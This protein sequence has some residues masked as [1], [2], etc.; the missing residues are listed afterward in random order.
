VSALL[1]DIQ[2]PAIQ[3]LVAGAGDRRFDGEGVGAV[4]AE[5]HRV[6]IGGVVALPLD[7]VIDRKT[8][9]VLRGLQ[10]VVD[11]HNRRGVA[12]IGNARRQQRDAHGGIL[13]DAIHDLRGLLVAAGNEIR[14]RLHLDVRRGAGAGDGDRGRKDI[15]TGRPHDGRIWNPDSRRHGN[16]VAVR[17][18]SIP[19][20]PMRAG[21]IIDVLE[22][23]ERCAALRRNLQRCKC[24]L[25]VSRADLVTLVAI[26]VVR[27]STTARRHRRTRRCRYIEYEVIGTV[28][29]VDDRA[30][31]EPLSHLADHAFGF[32]FL[33][34]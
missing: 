26:R 32:G 4:R 22:R 8:A 34:K 30:V 18:A 29:C 31:T 5:E 33:K 16:E 21:R 6:R 15:D 27:H 7:R 12:G 10:D 17:P 3:R 20:E 14:V 28:R 24:R 11:Q 23:I 25:R 9:A 19:I 2:H 13:A 1:H